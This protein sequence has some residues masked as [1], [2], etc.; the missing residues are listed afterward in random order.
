MSTLVLSDKDRQL[1]RA[2]GEE[3]VCSG[4]ELA[5]RLGISRAGVW[6]AVRRLQSLG[7]EIHAVPGVGYRM[8]HRIELLDAAAIKHGLNAEAAARLG[9]MHVHEVVESTNTSLRQ[10]GRAGA[11]SGSLC[12]AEMQTSGRGRLGRR[13]QSPFAGNIYLSLL[14]HFS[15]PA[16]LEGLSL[17]V[18]TLLVRVL[19]AAGA[20]ETALKWPNDIHWN[21]RKLGG[22]LIELSGEAHGQCAVVVGIGLNCYLSSGS[23]AEI[24][25]PAAAL[26]QVPAVHALSR[27]RLVA[28]LLNVLLPALADY[29]SHGLAAYLDEWHSYHTFHGRAV[30]LERGDET[31]EGTVAGVTPAG[32][33]LL[34]GEDGVRREYSS[35][36]I[37][38]RA[39]VA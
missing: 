16:L 33:L 5:Q 34:D 10:A 14:W 30:R 19:R 18:G 36:D 12:L 35:G 31:V 25:Q 9:S 29:E 3:P 11:P 23:M 27:N 13:W 28:E 17:A 38:L 22:I 24:D 4:N 32:L 7:M 39:A 1:I 37:R 8:A 20:A 21:G 2:L 15:S 26:H 6:K